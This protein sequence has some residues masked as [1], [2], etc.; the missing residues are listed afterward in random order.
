M[1]SP[2]IPKH[3]PD[4]TPSLMRGDSTS[5]LSSVEDSRL[6]QI[7]NRLKPKYSHEPS[8]EDNK[9]D[10]AALHSPPDSPIKSIPGGFN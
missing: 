6:E 7:G 4:S 9:T 8:P 2:T 5:S 1:P 10:N 3:S